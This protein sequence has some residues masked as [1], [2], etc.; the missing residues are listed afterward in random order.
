MQVVKIPDHLKGGLNK[1]GRNLNKGAVRR[2]SSGKFAL[3]L[4]EGFPVLVNMKCSCMHVAA[5]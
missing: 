4:C 2:M 3:T 1:A 5:I